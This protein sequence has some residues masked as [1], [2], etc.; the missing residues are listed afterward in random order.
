MVANALYRRRMDF[1]LNIPLNFDED[2][3]LATYNI[4]VHR[5]DGSKMAYRPS[6]NTDAARG[7]MLME[8][9]AA[10]QAGDYMKLHGTFQIANTLTIP[11]DNVTISG[12]GMGTTAITCPALDGSTTYNK[13]VLNG[14][15]NV[16]LENFKLGSLNQVPGF[17]GNGIVCTG[18]GTNNRISNVW[19]DKLADQISL[20]TTNSNDKGFDIERCFLTDGLGIALKINAGCE[21]N[22]MSE[23]RIN[24]VS[25]SNGR[26]LFDAAGNNTYN[27]CRIESCYNGLY[28]SPGSNHGHSTWTGGSINHTTESGVAIEIQDGYRS[29]H[30]IGLNVFSS[31]IFIAGANGIRFTGC[32]FDCGIRTY[33]G[34][35]LQGDCYFDN[36]NVNHS[37][38]TTTFLDILGVAMLAGDRTKIK[39]TNCHDMQMG[40]AWAEND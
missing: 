40:T 18:T 33:S 9:W 26:A 32:N 5:A 7:A 30:F 29:F 12:S 17:N 20:S 6:V 31:R 21:Y 35:P 13:I 22:R 23:V 8:A 4:L 39:V 27:D 37:G 28:L 38:A 36:C 34:T 2:E 16:T 3:A 14:R 11:A 15:S 10:L 25:V 19:V 1:R 24:G